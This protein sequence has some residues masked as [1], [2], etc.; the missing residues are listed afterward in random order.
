MRRSDEGAIGRQ[1]IFV[2][3]PATLLACLFMT[4]IRI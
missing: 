2:A 1:P 3:V 4:L